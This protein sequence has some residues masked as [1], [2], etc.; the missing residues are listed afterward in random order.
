MNPKKIDLLVGDCIL[1]Q[2][3]QR[4]A[5]VCIIQQNSLLVCLRFFF[6]KNMKAFV[7]FG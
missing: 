3:S 7:P 1:E 2:L 4:G 5:R 6:P